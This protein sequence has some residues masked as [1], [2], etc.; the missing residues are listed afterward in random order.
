MPNNKKTVRDLV[1][2]ADSAAIV[3]YLIDYF[4][5]PDIPELYSE[6][7]AGI[8]VKAKPGLHSKE[9]KVGSYDRTIDREGR[10][11]YKEILLDSDKEGGGYGPIQFE[12]EKNPEVVSKDVWWRRTPRNTLLHEAFGHGM[13]DAVYGYQK[14]PHFSRTETFPYMLSV[15]S[16]ILKMKE[17]GVPEDDYI[18]KLHL[19]AFDELREM[20]GKQLNIGD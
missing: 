15:Y 19:D 5:R 10:V 20:S 18:Y 12:A 9:G 13:L 1:A 8:P 11:K 17:E 16:Q 2:P 14:K 3:D 7:V 6:Q 4:N